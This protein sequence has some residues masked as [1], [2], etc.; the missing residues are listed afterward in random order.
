LGVVFDDIFFFSLLFG[1]FMGASKYLYR[2]NRYIYGL[3]KAV[4]A[5]CSAIAWGGLGRKGRIMVNTDP[6]EYIILN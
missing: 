1:I 4:V 2:M 5:L 6:S 3:S